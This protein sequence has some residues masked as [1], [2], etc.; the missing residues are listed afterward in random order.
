MHSGRV[1]HFYRGPTNTPL[2]RPNN[3]SLTYPSHIPYPPLYP[4]L[5]PCPVAVFITSIG[6]L[7]IHLLNGLII[8]PLHTHPIYLTCPCTLIYIHAQWPSSSLLPE[9]NTVSIY[10][11]ESCPVAG[12]VTILNPLYYILPSSTS[13]HCTHSCHNT[14]SS[15][16]CHAQYQV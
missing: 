4:Y 8:H 3:T 5:Y 2:E 6:A 12:T 10:A 16:S 1:H 7:L 11:T 9:R 15:R 13:C 14:L